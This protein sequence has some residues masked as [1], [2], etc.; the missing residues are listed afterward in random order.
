MNKQTWYKWHSYAGFPLA[1]FLCFIMF[2][3]TLAVLSHELDWLA[4]P[5]IR[6]GSEKA[7]ID[8]PA[9]YRS[10]LAT[11]N[12]DRIYL[13]SEPHHDGFAAEAIFLNSQSQRYRAFFHPTTLQHTGNGVWLNWQTTL[14]RLHRHL[15]LPLNIGL[16]VVSA[17]AFLLFFS[18]L[19]GL[20]LHPH[21]W[22]GLWRLPRR[23]NVRTFWGDT[24]RLTG[25]WSSWLLLII[26]VTGIWYFLEKH[27][28]P[29]SYPANGTVTSEQAHVSAVKVNPEVLSKAIQQTISLRP[30]LHITSIY[31]PVKPG[32]P[33]RIDGQTHDV[34]VR[35]RANN[36]I[37]D[38]V[39]AELLSQR[40]GKSLSFHARI[41]EAAD[42]LHFGTWGGYWSKIL[43]FTF[44]LVLTSLCITG[45]IIYAHRTFK[46]RRHAI[47]P[48][49]RVL[50]SGIKKMAVGA[51]LSFSLILLSLTLTVIALLEA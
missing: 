30:E 4:N 15:M 5:A 8:W 44:G 17:T 3:G 2:T 19:S 18:M 49:S 13:L 6:A 25:L 23:N 38:P 1:V 48:M 26:A 21:W 37:F 27:G 20:M 28:L 22:Q 42:P 34:L 41:S 47:P 9:Y 39:T 40:Q 32:Q 10:A 45:T 24:H 29:A 7:P 14:R 31:L 12:G 51:V 33:I 35:D 50:H 36:L 11:A 46:W 16:T 43:Y